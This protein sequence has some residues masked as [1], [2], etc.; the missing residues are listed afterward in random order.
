MHSDTKKSGQ[1]KTAKTDEKI[2]NVQKL[3]RSGR[4]LTVRLMA[5]MLSLNKES[6]RKVLIED[7]STRKVRVE[8]VLKPLTG[9]EKPKSV[10]LCVELTSLPT[11]SLCGQLESLVT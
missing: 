1:P 2:R 11:G 3:V 9:G 4:R 6:I 10:A 8:M 7:L 5:Q